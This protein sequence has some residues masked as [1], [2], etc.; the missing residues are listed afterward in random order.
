MFDI[1]MVVKRIREL[2]EKLSR[3]VLVGV[4][5]VGG[6]GKSTFARELAEAIG[7]PIVGMDDFYRVMDEEKR[8]RLSLEE[9]VWR[10]FDWERLRIS[11]VFKALKGCR[12]LYYEAYDWSKNQLGDIREINI[13]DVLIV[14]GVYSCLP[15]IAVYDLKIWIDVPRGVATQR[16]RDRG[17]NEEVWIKRW[18][19]SEDWYVEQLVNLER[20]DFVYSGESGQLVRCENNEKTS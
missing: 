3:P 20:F 1:E 10:Y 16:V 7:E 13:K 17:E 15:T 6:C 2:S 19:A 11:V 8:A 9:G 18:A 5:G 12:H 14:E 4:D